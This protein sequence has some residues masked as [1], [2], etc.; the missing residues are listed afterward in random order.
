MFLRIKSRYSVHE[1]LKFL[2]VHKRHY[3]ETLT[4]NMF[5]D[6]DNLHCYVSPGLEPWLP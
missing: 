3:T 4:S 2:R 5:E 6:T 1:D